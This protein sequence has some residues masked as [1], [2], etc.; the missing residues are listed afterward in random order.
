[1]LRVEVALHA[2]TQLMELSPRDTEFAGEACR[3]FAFGDPA[4]EQ[5]ELGRWLFGFGKDRPAQQ[6]VVAITL[7]TAVAQERA[8]TPG[9]PSRRGTTS[10]APQP[11]R[12][13]LLLQPLGTSIV[14]EQLVNGEVNHIPKLYLNPQTDFT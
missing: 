4:Q 13:K 6:R 10:G 11:S 9:N 14:V 2:P 3:R 1:L 5:H 8:A 7:A 12:V